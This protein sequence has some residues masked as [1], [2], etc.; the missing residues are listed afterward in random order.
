MRSCRGLPL[1]FSHGVQSLD[2]YLEILQNVNT[3]QFT[4][5]ILMLYNKF[6]EKQEI[7]IV[8]P[9][10]F[11]YLLKVNTNVMIMLSVYKI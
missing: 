6:N 4:Q 1:L 9:R 10:N 2:L 8:V 5:N 3:V 7:N 11:L